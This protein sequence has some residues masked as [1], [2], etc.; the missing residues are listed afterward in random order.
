MFVVLVMK[1]YKEYEG[2][3]MAKGHTHTGSRSNNK[4]ISALPQNG[5]VSDSEN[6][7]TICT[8]KCC[9]HSNNKRILDFLEKSSHIN[10]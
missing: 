2:I 3:K 4:I 7:K 9:L 8:E 5:L 1:D 10:H 6:C